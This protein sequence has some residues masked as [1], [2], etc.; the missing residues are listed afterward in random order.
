M[1]NLKQKT[2]LKDYCGQKVL[3]QINNQPKR[4]KL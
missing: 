3:T 4:N 2:I 1:E